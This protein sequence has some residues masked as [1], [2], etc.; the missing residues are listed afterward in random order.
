M[1]NPFAPS[2]DSGIGRNVGERQ[3]ILERLHELRGIK[4]VSILAEK[5]KLYPLENMKA[6][7]VRMGA[8]PYVLSGASHFLYAAP[9][10]AQIIADIITQ[11]LASRP[12]LPHN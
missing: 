10:N 3:P 4:K 6:E 1:G 7:V 2:C 9:G 8:D 11:V 12:V 5:D